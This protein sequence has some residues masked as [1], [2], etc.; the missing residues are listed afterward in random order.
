[1]FC[2]KFV[3]RCF[4]TLERF[5]DRI[6]G[7][8]GPYFVGFA[9][10]LIST[11]TICFCEFLSHSLH[12]ITLNHY[13]VDVVMPTLSYPLISGPICILIALN[14]FMHYYY[15]C[16]VPPGFVDEP[17]REPGTGLLWSRPRIAQTQRPMT[18][19]VR[20]SSELNITKASVTRCRK[21]GQ[22]K[23]EVCCHEEVG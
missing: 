19:G 23:P 1:M 7:A 16:T 4:K 21:C 10:I 22:S 3:F 18:Q 2:S 5:G 8:A 20:W 17:P 9:V 13:S 15:V 12:D 14:L 11:G 6:T